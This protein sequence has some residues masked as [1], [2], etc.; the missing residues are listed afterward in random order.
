MYK[1]IQEAPNLNCRGEVSHEEKQ[2]LNGKCQI[3]VAVADPVTSKT[4]SELL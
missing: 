1:R 2:A 4:T 3:L